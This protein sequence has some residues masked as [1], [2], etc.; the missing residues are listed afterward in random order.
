M[1]IG[2]IRQETGG[3]EREHPRKLDLEAFG[4]YFVEIK[5]KGNS[6]ES[7]TVTQSKY[8]RQELQQPHSDINLA[9]KPWSFNLSCLQ[10]VLK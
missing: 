8:R 4:G 1:R 3:N 6:L 5:S 10:N 9:I 2:E 7:G